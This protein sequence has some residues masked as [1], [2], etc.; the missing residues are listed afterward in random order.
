MSSPRRQKPEESDIVQ[1]S[2]CDSYWHTHTDLD[3]CAILQSPDLDQSNQDLLLSLDCL[4]SM[5]SSKHVKHPAL[6][7]LV[8][9]IQMSQGCVLVDC[10]NREI[11]FPS[12]RT[13]QV[14]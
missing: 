10:S 9:H 5:W 7:I 13:D 14:I 12:P 8:L 6:L 1:L 3:H 2:Y 4:V 11:L